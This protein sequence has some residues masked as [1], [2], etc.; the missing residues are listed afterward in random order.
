MEPAQWSHKHVDVSLNAHL[1]IYIPVIYLWIYVSVYLWIYASMYLCIYASMYLCIYA[2]MYLCICVYVYVNT[3]TYVYIR[4]MTTST[5]TQPCLHS[6]L[7]RCRTH[8]RAAHGELREPSQLSRLSLSR[9]FPRFRIA[10]CVRGWSWNSKRNATPHHTFPLAVEALFT[11]LALLF[12][13]L[14]L[15]EIS[16]QGPRV[17]LYILSSPNTFCKHSKRTLRY[18]KC[19]WATPSPRQ[20]TPSR[21][22][23]IAH[24]TPRPVGVCYSSELKSR[25]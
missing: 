15:T 1:E 24:Y 2:S 6:N 8:L 16:C 21:S 19:P 4:S 20:P 7:L 25:F 17:K 3:Y 5:A 13:Y 14:P 9:A 22:P 11:A 12:C 23:L 10:V 18:L